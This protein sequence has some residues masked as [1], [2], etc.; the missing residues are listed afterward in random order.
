[1]RPRHQLTEKEQKAQ[2]GP[3]NGRKSTRYNVFT[4]LPMTILYQFTR[5]V[6]CFYTFNA[7]L[8]SLPAVS[9]NNPLATIIPLSTVILIGIAKEVV[10]EVK[11][12]R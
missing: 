7:V 11:R 9:T 8:Q 6:N 3:W 2:D 4:F 10:V 5:V 1:V 12:W